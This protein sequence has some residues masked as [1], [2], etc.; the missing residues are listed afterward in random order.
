MICPALGGESRSPAYSLRKKSRAAGDRL[1]QSSAC[2][3]KLSRLRCE[4]GVAE[5]VID[6]HVGV[7][8]VA[9]RQRRVLCRIA[10][11]NSRPMV[12]RAAGVDHGDAL[13]ADDEADIGDV[14]VPA[15][16]PAPTGLPMCTKTPG[17]GSIRSKPVARRA[18][19]R[20]RSAQ[21][22]QPRDGEC[23][24]SAAPIG[25]GVMCL[26]LRIQRIDRDGHAAAGVS[27]AIRSV[28]FSLKE[29]PVCA[30]S[31]RLPPALTRTLRDVVS[32]YRIPAARIDLKARG[33]GVSDCDLHRFRIGRAHPDLTRACRLPAALGGAEQPPL[34]FTQLLRI[35]NPP[36]AV[37]AMARTEVNRSIR[38]RMLI[39]VNARCPQNPTSRPAATDCCR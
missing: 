2:P 38:T 21:T 5:H 25:C 1:R 39:S 34:A 18:A 8:D 6:V 4:R 15:A 33:V 12:D 30:S 20:T 23:A 22:K 36:S 35:S 19:R 29:M 32:R 13:L 16:H 17:S 7:D 26:R 10:A 3:T 9:D 24:D 28:G 11:R 14:V 31:K 27:A 37:S